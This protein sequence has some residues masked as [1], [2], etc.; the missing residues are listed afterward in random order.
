MS[1]LAPY[2]PPGAAEIDYTWN[3]ANKLCKTEFV[4]SGLRNRPEAV[5]AVFLTGR[6]LGIGPMQSLRDIYPVNGRPALMASLMVARVRGLGHRFKTLQSTDVQAIVQVHRKGEPEPEPPVAFGQVDAKRAGLNGK[7]NY[8]KYPKAMYWNRAAAAACRRDCPE[9]L[10]GAVYTPEELGDGD[11]TTTATWGAPEASEQSDP[12]LRTGG[13]GSMTPGDAGDSAPYSPGSD[14]TSEAVG[15]AG[16]NSAASLL[17]PAS[18]HN[19]GA[20]ERRSGRSNPRDV[21]H[22]PAPAKSSP[23][24]NDPEVPT[25]ADRSRA[26]GAHVDGSESGVGTPPSDAT[27]APDGAAVAPRQQPSGA[28]NRPT[29]GGAKGAQRDSSA[30]GRQSTEPVESHGAAAGRDHTEQADQAEF[31]AMQS[32]DDP[33]RHTR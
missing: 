6:E 29:S 19:A 22:D 25:E 16:G 27:A 1:E 8:Q 24:P 3:L 20:G 15:V 23:S 17:A 4:P 14:P 12:G 11:G 26:E 5:L 2:T 30:R 31:E 10:G 33:R 28:S 32:E 7:E 13:V 9:A 18:D 21:R